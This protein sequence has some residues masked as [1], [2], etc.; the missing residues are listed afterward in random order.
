MALIALHCF[1][2]FKV[3]VVPSLGAITNTV[4]VFVMSCRYYIDLLIC[5]HWSLYCVMLNSIFLFQKCWCPQ[6]VTKFLCRTFSFLYLRASNVLFIVKEIVGF[7][8][9]FCTSHWWSEEFCTLRAVIWQCLCQKVYRFQ[10]LYML[11]YD[12][13]LLGNYGNWL[14]PLNINCL[15]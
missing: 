1:I 15:A 8:L 2:G 11:R 13:A 9:V 14:F 4:E 7:G 3:V 12:L 10:I 6:F 5:Q